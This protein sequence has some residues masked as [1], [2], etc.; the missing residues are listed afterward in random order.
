MNVWTGRG[1]GG[2]LVSGGAVAPAYLGRENE[3][4]VGVGVSGCVTCQGQKGGRRAATSSVSA[5]AAGQLHVSDREGGSKN[6]G[7]ISSQKAFF[8]KGGIPWKPIGGAALNCVQDT[9]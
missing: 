9:Q 3:T 5:N 2:N 1:E 4:S 6:N 7:V 8:L